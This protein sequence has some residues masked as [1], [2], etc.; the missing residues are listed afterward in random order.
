MPVVTLDLG[1]LI[2]ALVAF[3]GV[4]ATLIGV[5]WSASKTRASAQDT[6]IT[7][8]I[9][10]ALNA[11]ADQ[12]KELKAEVKELKDELDVTKAQNDKQG[13]E[14]RRIKKVIADWFYELAAKWIVFTDEPMPMVSA[15][16]LALLEISP[17]LIPVKRRK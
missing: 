14:L 8:R 17:H 2:T 12:I 9:E 3:L 13:L 5:I 4:I 11:Q 7:D 6:T 16:D 10:L 15:E 1:Q